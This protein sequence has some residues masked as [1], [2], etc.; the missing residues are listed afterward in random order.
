MKVFALTFVLGLILNEFIH[1]GTEFLVKI[2]NIVKWVSKEFTLHKDLKNV[3]VETNPC[4][5]DRHKICY[6]NLAFEN[7]EISLGSFHLQIT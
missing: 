7:S 3:D 1:F 5:R 6:W 2:I 4:I